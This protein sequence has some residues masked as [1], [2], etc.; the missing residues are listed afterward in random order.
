M[1][2]T[3]EFE[4]LDELFRKTFDNLPET[5]AQTGWDTPSERVWQHVQSQIKPPRSG[6]S[7]Q[8]ISLVTAFAVTLAVGLYL[9]LGRTEKPDAT[10]PTPPPAVVAEAAESPAANIAD[11][12][13]QQLTEAETTASSTTSTSP[14]KRTAKTLK[15]DAHGNDADAEAVKADPN[16]TAMGSGL[17]PDDKKPVPPNTTERRKAELAKRAET[18]WKTPLQSLPQRWPKEVNIDANN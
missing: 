6:W 8:T 7:A 17:K 1:A 10:V 3:K 16:D 12:T 2:D 13:E 5:P 15:T 14:G 18:A 4:S 11:A 9:I